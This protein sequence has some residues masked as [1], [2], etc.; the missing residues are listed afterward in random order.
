MRHQQL[1]LK[2]LVAGS[3][4]VVLAT[5]VAAT[6]VDAIY[7]THPGDQQ[8][9][10]ITRAVWSD[11]DGGSWGV[12]VPDPQVDQVLGISFERGVNI[13]DAGVGVD[14]ASII[15]GWLRAVAEGGPVGG[16]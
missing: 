15:E 12:V 16:R 13:D 9:S 3:A 8:E 1:K 11:T 7:F 5:V 14:M 4:V 6:A 2:R 10:G